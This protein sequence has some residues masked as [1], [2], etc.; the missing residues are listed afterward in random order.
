[1]DYILYIIF[2]GLIFGALIVAIRTSRYLGYPR[3]KEQNN[4]YIQR[5][6]KPMYREYENLGE[7]VEIPKEAKN[8]LDS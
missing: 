3:R 5:K 4:T 2:G 7:R 6:I 8:K 1:M